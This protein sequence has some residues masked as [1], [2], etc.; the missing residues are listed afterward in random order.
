M[1]AQTTS[2]AE[3]L[4]EL[5]EKKRLYAADVEE[6]AQLMRVSTRPVPTGVD[7]EGREFFGPDDIRNWLDRAP[8]YRSPAIAAPTQRREAAITAAGAPRSWD[9]TTRTFEARIA[10]DAPVMMLDWE[11][12]SLLPEI[13]IPEG[14]DVPPSVPLQLDHDRSATATVGRM[15]QPRRDAMGWTMR[16]E[17]GHGPAEDS[18]AQ[19]I[20][21]GFL[22]GVSI[23]YTVQ[24][25]KR[26]KPGES[27]SVGGR[28]IRNDGESY[29]IVATRWRL[30]EVSI[31]A[32]P[33]DDGARIRSTEGTNSMGRVLVPPAPFRHRY[34]HQM[35]PSQQREALCDAAARSNLS[36]ID[37]QNACVAAAQGRSALVDLIDGSHQAIF[38][39]AFDATGDTTQGWTAV[40][41][42]ASYAPRQT[43]SPVGGRLGVTPRGATAPNLAV[44]AIASHPARAY[45][46]AAKEF[47][48]AMDLLN[49][50]TT[51]IDPGKAVTR[52]MGLAAARVRPDAVYSMLLS[53][54][55]LADGAPLF[56]AGRGNVVGGAV[57][58]ATLQAAMAALH[59]MQVAGLTLAA[60]TTHILVPP[61]IEWDAKALMR[62][63]D[64]QDSPAPRVVAESRLE[65][66]LADPLTGEALAGS[67][68]AVYLVSAL[69]PPVKVSYF[70]GDNR[71]PRI[72][73]WVEAGYPR[74]GVGYAASLSLSVSVLGPY[75][76]KIV[77]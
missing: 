15:T 34:L 2:A 65:K 45:R 26:L 46:Y 3:R 7:G 23:G 51:G 5:R 76:V 31:V 21:R 28:V 32:V 75:A 43:I 68:T 22:T 17:I 39:E 62:A 38:W 72:T 67:A 49:G 27:I 64:L 14:G 29:L 35:T 58:A 53:N 37:L 24:E 6:L 44:E 1:E 73:R 9:G 47:V 4:A 41:D 52:E 60:P 13:L 66:G 42:D 61:S 57:S 36:R 12:G 77:V 55:A 20:S 50:V 69:R 16:G 74:D 48:D 71:R 18:I 19:K 33:A 11:S 54:P 56:D 10:T 8:R 70:P 59:N 25:R 30:F 63:I 40:D